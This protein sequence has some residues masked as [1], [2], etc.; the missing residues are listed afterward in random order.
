M[1]IHE[2]RQTYDDLTE[3]Y[4]QLELRNYTKLANIQ[5]IVLRVEEHT[6]LAMHYSLR[7]QCMKSRHQQEEADLE[8]SI[9]AE[10]NEL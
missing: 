5:V 4:R 9:C 3:K 6:H 10:L 1:L 8:A 7:R 2:E